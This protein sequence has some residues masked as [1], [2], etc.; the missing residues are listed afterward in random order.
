MRLAGIMALIGAVVIGYFLI[1]GGGSGGGANT[2]P[3][4][5]TPPPGPGQIAAGPSGLMAGEGMHVQFTDPEDPS[6]VTGELRSRS[7]EPQDARRY[8][9]VEPQMWLYQDDGSTVMVKAAD[10]RLYMPSQ[11]QEPE[12]GRLEGGVVVHLYDP[13]DDGSRVTTEGNDEPVMIAR[14]EWLDFDMAL[15]EASTDSTL[16]VDTEQVSFTGHRLRARFDELRERLVFLEVLDGGRIAYTPAD[17]TD[18]PPPAPVTPEQPRASSDPSRKLG[19]AKPSGESPKPVEP[20][21]VLYYTTIEQEVALWQAGRVLEA[22][23]LEI[24]ART[25]DNALRDSAIRRVEF[26]ETGA[27]QARAPV[28]T[29]LVPTVVAMAVG[30]SQPEQAES[31]VITLEWVGPLRVQPVEDAEQLLDDDLTFRFSSE[32]ADGVT[33]RDDESHAQGAMQSLAYRATTA[34][35]DAVGS[36]SE[37]GWLDAPDQGR[38]EFEQ[39]HVDLANGL[40]SLTGRALAQA[41]ENDSQ[42]SCTNGADLALHFIDAKVSTLLREAIFNGNVVA[43]NGQASAIGEIARG[44]FALDSDETGAVISRLEQFH[45]EGDDQSVAQLVQGEDEALEGRVIDVT[46]VPGPDDEPDPSYIAVTGDVHGRQRDAQLTAGSL[47]AELSRNDDGDLVIDRAD[48]DGGVHFVRT[49]DDI[50]IAA[51]SLQA[52]PKEERV[53]FAGEQSMVRRGTAS[54]HGRQ[55]DLDGAHR[56]VNVFGAGRFDDKLGSGTTASW[57]REMVFDDDEGLLECHGDVI[58]VI[59][60]DELTKDTI[61]AM[62][63]FARMEPVDPDSAKQP[64]GLDALDGS[65]EDLVG[66]RQLV[67]AVAIGEVEEIENGLPAIIQSIEHE[68]V[69]DADGHETLHPARAMLLEGPRIQLGEGGDRLDV[70]AAGRLVVADQREPNEPVREED[71][72]AARGQAMFTWT[73]DFS[74]DRRAGEAVMQ[75]GV[76]ATMIEPDVQRV[77]LLDAERMIALLSEEE[78]G[79]P[80]LSGA[81][82]EGAVYLAQK[83]EGVTSFE[84]IAD[85]LMLDNIAKT[86]EATSADGNV[87]TV[88][89]GSRP[90]PAT[91]KMFFFD[92][93]AGRWEVR[94]PGMITTPR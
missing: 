53:T 77:T 82:A 72:T 39:A 63:V 20:E 75:R 92:L 3:D 19:Q 17:K 15:G 28:M 52:W 79:Q 88:F 33:L 27:R 47:E 45:L 36:A 41:S 9:V 91:A 84:V 35:I 7:V 51:E 2:I 90:T 8:L 4:V 16:T 59:Q 6:K 13:R 24:W 48:A 71:M 32:A 37:P 11:S 65:M 18:S 69:I 14:T 30:A 60:R 38:V 70:P 40:V 64:S 89:E 94:S 58:A 56:R 34:R 5:P 22:D 31:D 68:V 66:E 1:W 80:S 85:A 57:S 50:E 87:V 12:S 44:S 74:F 93:E 81:R 26:A 62:R 25:F 73:G 10:G 49:G 42:I 78:A 55:I 23:L 86:A 67:S 83:D 43:T 54:I 29:P 21:P 46:L 76:R 61:R